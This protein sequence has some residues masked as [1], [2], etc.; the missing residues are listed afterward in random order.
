VSR[1]FRGTEIG[2]ATATEI[3]TEIAI[4][5]VIEIEI[6]TEI[7]IATEIG[8]ASTKAPAFTIR[9][10]MAGTVTAPML[11]SRATGTA[12]SQVQTMAA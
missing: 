1:T 11:M 7:A 8:I 3:V 2:I 10:I 9:R 5:A 12:C 6:A 4:V